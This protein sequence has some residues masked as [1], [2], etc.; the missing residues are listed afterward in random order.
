MLVVVDGPHGFD[1]IQVGTAHVREVEDLEQELE[2]EQV[3]LPASGKSPSAQDKPEKGEAELQS[4]EV[5]VLP[6]QPL[7]TSWW[8][9]S[10][11]RPSYLRA[12][13]IA[14]TGCI[15]AG[16]GPFTIVFQRH[17]QTSHQRNLCRCH[18]RS[19]SPSWAPRLRQ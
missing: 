10:L 9:L 16:F 12:V 5:H 7:V 3:E 6:R 4:N 13:R 18:L 15:C 19:P 1:D 2:K 17:P 8:S 11:F 14:L